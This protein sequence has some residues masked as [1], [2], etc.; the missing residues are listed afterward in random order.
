MS[1]ELTA[2]TRHRCD[3]T[4]KLM[5]VTLNLNIQQQQFLFKGWCSVYFFSFVFYFK[6][7]F[8]PANSD[9]TPLS[10]LGL[11]CLPGYNLWD[12]VVENTGQS[13]PWA[14]N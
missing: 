11:H 2:T 10:D 8:L 5:K 12:A 13:D 9:P 1:T 3:M 7:K 4:E 14:S 6:E